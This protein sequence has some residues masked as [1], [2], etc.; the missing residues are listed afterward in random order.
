MLSPFIERYLRGNGIPHRLL[1]A[2]AAQ[3]EPPPSEDAIPVVRVRSVLIEADG[4][5]VLCAIPEDAEVDLDA[6]A[7]LLQ[8]EEVVICEEGRHLDLF[9][10]CD[11]GAVPPLGGL[12]SLPLIVDAEVELSDRILMPAGNF[13]TYIEMRTMDLLYLEEPTVA[14]IA[15]FPGEPWKHAMPVSWHPA[16]IAPP[17][18]H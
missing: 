12:W 8:A 5:E 1:S 2:E 7:D 14:D 9:P 6:L 16:E 15:V 4:D 11:F 3:V 13:D 18:R 17:T 10:G